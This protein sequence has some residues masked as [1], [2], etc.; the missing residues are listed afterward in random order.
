M[1]TRISILLVSE[2]RVKKTENPIC[3]F[4]DQVVISSPLTSE[5][6]SKTVLQKLG[7]S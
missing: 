6:L 5:V 7:N 2:K 4:S 3:K 1:T